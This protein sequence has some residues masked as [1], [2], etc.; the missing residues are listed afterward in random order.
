MATGHFFCPIDVT[1]T[2]ISGKWKP[3]VLFLLKKGPQRFNA[4]LAQMPGVS[5]KVLAQQQRSLERD[6]IIE[7]AVDAKDVV[8]YRMT[9]FGRTLR[10]ALTEL[11]AWGIKHRRRRAEFSSAT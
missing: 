7:R 8:S 4:L 3:M 9:E 10:P 5:H 1:L 6:G 2:M 11:A